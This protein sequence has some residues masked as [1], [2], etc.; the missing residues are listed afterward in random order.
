MNRIELR[1]VI[2]PSEYGTSEYMQKYITAGII[3]PEITFRKALDAAPV[4]A[5]LDVYVNSPGGSVFAANEMINAVRDWKAQTKQE[6]IVTIGAMAA[7]A[8]SAF[9]IMASDKIRAHKNAKMM[10]HGAWT[11]ILG[12]KEM[13]EDTAD[14]LGKINAD[15]KGR[16]VSKYG[17]KKETVDEW[18][19]EGREGWLSAEEMSA[20][21]ISSETIEDGSDVIQFTPEA[22]AEIEQGGLG[23]AAFLKT[24]VN[25]EDKNACDTAGIDTPAS[26][27]VAEVKPDVVVS[28]DKAAIDI[29]QYNA[30]IAV[31]RAKQLA[32][33]A[34]SIE[35]LQEQ[36]KQLGDQSRKYQG[37]RD[38]ARAEA[39]KLAGELSALK[40]K[41]ESELKK[42]N[43]DHSKIL[44]DMKLEM[45]T[46]QAK[47][48]RLVNGGMSFS[49]VADKAGSTAGDVDPRNQLHPSL[50]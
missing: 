10:F 15:I 14:L 37:D 26:A 27:V 43:E 1:G 11:M 42:I 48:E 5:P 32:D 45:G 36:V 31:G 47:C 23:I 44:T 24:Q 3:T 38:K 8:A 46:V 28:S 20:S 40:V 22:V 2:V 49:P 25:E 19:A 7:S 30:G 13:H 35:K 34:E 9:A 21:G 50:R 4:D 6:V 12:G 39:E 16:L 41:N 18:F 29:E 17:M 33:D